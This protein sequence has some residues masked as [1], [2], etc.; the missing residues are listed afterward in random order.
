MLDF[1]LWSR[2]P[3]ASPH[4]LLLW[5][6]YTVFLLLWYVGLAMMCFIKPCWLLPCILEE[7]TGIARVFDAHTF[8]KSHAYKL[9]YLS[10]VKFTDCW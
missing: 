4:V 6:R 2:F 1:S 7:P 9:K 3:A 5:G 10:T 8:E